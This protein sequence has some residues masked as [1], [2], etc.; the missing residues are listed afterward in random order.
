MW[1][2]RTNDRGR[3]FRLV[4]APVETPDRENWTEQIAH[5]DGMMIEEIDLFADFFVACEREDG[6]PRLRVWRF[7]GSGAE[8]VP[9]SEI[10]FPEPAYNAQPHVNRVFES[11]TFRYSYQSLVTPASVYE[12]HV[13]T[14]A[15]TLLKQLEI[16]G[17]FDRALYASERVHATAPDGVRVPIS[18]VYR[19]T[20]LPIA[21]R[22]RTPCMSMVMALMAMHCPWA[23]AP[24][25]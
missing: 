24:T 18:L 8:A 7:N 19:E 16:P 25:G 1:F 15:S 10:D 6:L 20:N 11:P 21:K 2:I 14:N 5:R 22:E 13:A 23:S 17:G 3:N 4:T 12:Y 9:A